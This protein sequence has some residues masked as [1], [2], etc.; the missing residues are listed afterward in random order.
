[1]PQNYNNGAVKMEE[2]KLQTLTIEQQK[3]LTM[4]GVISVDGFNEQTVTVTLNEGR[5]QINGDG[6]K[7]LAFSKTTGNLSIDGKIYTVK[8]A[9]KKQPLM[10]RLLK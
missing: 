10:K 6:L 5:M 7:V 8:F 1:M 2:N 4:S 3:R 9:L